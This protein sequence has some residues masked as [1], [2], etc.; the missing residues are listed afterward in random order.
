ML[1]TL[2]LVKSIP[3]ACCESERLFQSISLL[4]VC[5]CVHT[6][7]MKGLGWSNMSLSVCTQPCKCIF[8]AQS[9]ITSLLKDMPTNVQPHTHICKYDIRVRHACIPALLCVCVCV[10]M[11]VCVRVCVCLCV[12]RCLLSPEPQ[13]GSSHQYSPSSQHVGC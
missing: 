13:P 9:A 1:P 5:V 11:S 4:F 12:S 10:C 8:H 7:C 6:L 3:A 2:C